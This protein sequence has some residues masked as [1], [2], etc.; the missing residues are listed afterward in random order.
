MKIIK[1]IFFGIL[2]VI[3]TANIAVSQYL[4]EF[5]CGTSALPNQPSNSYNSHSKDG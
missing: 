4:I 2:I 3:I 1:T 5:N